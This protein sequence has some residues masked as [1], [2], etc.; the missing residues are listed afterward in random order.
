MRRTCPPDIIPFDRF[1]RAGH[2]MR[3]RTSAKRKWSMFALLLLLGGIISVY[4]YITNSNRVR[5]MAESY[6]SQVLGGRVEVRHATLSIFEGLRLDDVTVHLPRPA[7]APAL[8]AANQPPPIFSADT[9]VIRYSLKK[10]LTGRIEA[11]QIIA[12]RPHVQLTED[13]ETLISNYRNG[14]RET[15]VDETDDDGHRPLKR[16]V[17]PPLPEISLRDARVDYR[18]LRPDG[19]TSLGTLSLEGQFSPI[20]DSGDGNRRYRF[21]L[22]SRGMSDK[23]GPYVEGEIH[24]AAGEVRGRLRNFELGTDI[25]LMLPETVRQWW[26]QHEL[27][28]KVDITELSYA[29]PPV[30]RPVT[31][32][33]FSVTT[34]LQG[35][36]LTVQPG[37]LQGTEE[38]NRVADVRSVLDTMTDL[39]AT[40]GYPSVAI[41]NPMAPFHALFASGPLRL[42]NM[43]GTFVFNDTGIVIQNALGD[44]EGN[45]IY[46]DGQLDGYPGIAGVQEPPAKLR[47]TSGGKPL[48]LPAAPGYTNA[49]PRAVREIY[50]QLRPQ[51]SCLLDVSVSRPT[52]GARLSV[53]GGIEVL[54]GN[55]VFLRFPYPV[56]KA[57]GSISFEP[58]D[59]NG[60]ERLEINL[61]GMG[62]A[63]GANENTIINV[64]GLMGPLGNDAGVGIRIWSDDVYNEPAMTHAFPA[65]VQRTLA[66]FDAEGLGNFPTFRGRFTCDVNRAVGP[67]KPWLLTTHV[68]IQSATGSLAAFPYPLQG[69]AM[70]LKIG[71]NSVEIINANMQK[72]D[73]KLRVDGRVSWAPTIPMRVGQRAIRQ[74]KPTAVTELKLIAENIAID[75]ELLAAI[76]EGSRDVLRKLGLRGVLD[77]TGIIRND[78]RLTPVD[79][80]PNAP[81]PVDY[82]LTALLRE[83]TVWP[84]GAS[85]VVG[86]VNG[87]IGLTPTKITFTDVNGSRGESKMTVNGSLSIPENATSGAVKRPPIADLSVNA[88]NLPLDGPLYALLPKPAQ[89]AWDT[90]QP[91]GTVD[92]A[93]KVDGSLPAKPSSAGTTMPAMKQKVTIIPR[94]LSVQLVDYPY[95]VDRITGRIVVEGNQTT[96]NQ[97]TGRNGDAMMSVWGKGI[98]N[99]DGDVWNLSLFARDVPADDTFFDALPPSFATT[100]RSLK[101][102]GKLGWYVPKYVQKFKRSTSTTEAATASTQPSTVDMSGKVYFTG[103]SMDVGVPLAEIDG[104]L[105]GSVTIANGRIDEMVGSVD[106]DKLTVSERT[107]SNVHGAITRESGSDVLKLSKLSGELAGGYLV[108]DVSLTSPKP[109]LDNTPSKPVDKF[110]V[111]LVLRG[112][113]A[114]VIAGEGVSD[115]EGRLSA[116]LALEGVVDDANS[117]RGRGDVLVSGDNMYQLPLVLG[118]L[119]ITN[120]AL[121]VNT[122]MKEATARYTVDG[123]RINF[124]AISLR[125]DTLLMNGEGHL[126]Y[127]TRQV[128]MTF[129]TDNPNAPHIPFLSELWRNAQQEFFKIEVRGTV[130][131]PQVSNA[132]LNTITT[133]VDQVFRAKR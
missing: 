20:D 92:V 84:M 87:K 93:V 11:T 89:Q 91:R 29:L 100:L 110:M 12:R 17:P 67:M 82:N 113:D 4:G 5:Q 40:A 81:P 127:G 66:M 109:T 7:G 23:L 105:G 8:S 14:S 55:F 43:N 41:S 33:T 52:A 10:L 122:P 77:V 94:D 124:D 50:D 24:P 88:V 28:G 48:V 6:L 15:P 37:E 16:R 126:D 115:L 133:T 49:L 47:I 3:P 65:D 79:N 1:W 58:K 130:Q 25:R 116:S 119:Q 27:S 39:Y 34:Q 35:V 42:D 57:T 108:G 74:T 2:P 114:A 60:P 112:A 70:E 51:G 85:F 129:T 64:A 69:L 68:V 59:E 78:A 62:I 30:G 54:E 73:A 32:S 128:A 76:P 71:Q 102:T 95:P 83:G 75:D 123:Q 111:S 18:E 121:P 118:L 101:L 104:S 61:R 31:E 90:V 117:R 120:L 53:D 46:I 99:P 80:A 21:F 38:T 44:V 13:I 63:G 125:S 36:T 107:M 72:G 22:Q 45:R 103:V 106:F 9:F 131:E 97:V 86:D 56:R 96:L 132:A 98:S 26:V 19:T